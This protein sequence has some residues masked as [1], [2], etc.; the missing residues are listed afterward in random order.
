MSMMEAVQSV[1]GNYATFTGRARRS[2]YWYFVL[3]NFLVSFV[4]NLLAGAISHGEGP[5]MFLPAIW[6]LAV[7]IPSL[8]VSIR[9]LHD[10]GKVGWWVLIGLIPIVGEIVLIVFLATDSQPGTNQFGPN[11]KGM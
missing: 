3:F 1:F 5:I 10:T 8:A 9:R 7:A 6:G 2:E 11:P 4:L